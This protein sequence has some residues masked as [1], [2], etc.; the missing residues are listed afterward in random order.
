MMQDKL[1]EFGARLASIC[2]PYHYRRPD[3][4]PPAYLVWQETA[5]R[6]NLHADNRRA[7]VAVSGTADYYTTTEFDRQVE[8]V[9]AV[10]DEMG[11]VW[12]LTDVQYEL[13]TGTIHYAWDWSVAYA[14]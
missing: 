5:A 2:A 9:Q 6:P 10:M 14:L 4:C 7:E 3:N 13:D 8:A 12:E 11:M 1:R